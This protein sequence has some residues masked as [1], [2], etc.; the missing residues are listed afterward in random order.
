MADAERIAS[1]E[2]L[3]FTPSQ[4]GQRT[5]ANPLARRRYQK[6]SIRF[7]NGKYI[8][9]WREDVI[10][11]SGTVKRLNRKYIRNIMSTMSAM[12]DIAVNWRYVT[13]KPFASLILPACDRSDVEP[14]SQ[15]EVMKIFLAAQEP[16]KTFL[17]TL[18]ECGMRPGEV[19]ALDAKYI[20][21]DDRVISV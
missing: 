15:E 14:Y 6:G 9:R 10:L 20:H 1:P 16:F 21:L 5:G 19:C 4:P 8:G 17:W 18:G 3:Q 12:W 13:H 11:A 7:V 2:L